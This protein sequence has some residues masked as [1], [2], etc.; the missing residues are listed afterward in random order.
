MKLN[1][2][3]EC[4]APLHR[5]NSTDYL[6]D[7]GHPY[8]NEPHASTCVVILNDEGKLLLAK[9]G[10]EPRRDKYIFPGGF[11]EFGEDP[12]DAARREIREETSLECGELMLLEV[13]NIKYRENE[14][15]LSIVFLARDW[16]GHCEAGDDAAALRWCDI[17]VIDG[18]EFAWPF[19][20]LASKLRE[21]TEK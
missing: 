7:N 14:A 2:C 21:L 5:Q 1:Y 17:D 20:G 10:R 11:V 18:D 13:Q 9:R 12:Y 19:P 6:C 15:S 4:A 3:T 16:R 8:W